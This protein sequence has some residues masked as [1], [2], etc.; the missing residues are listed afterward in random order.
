MQIMDLYD[1]IIWVV[2][3]IGM[4]LIVFLTALALKWFG[5]S[6][7]IVILIGAVIG[8]PIACLVGWIAA[9]FLTR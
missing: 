8:F 6:N 9:Y 2:S 3:I 4:A 5:V 1:V 7:Q